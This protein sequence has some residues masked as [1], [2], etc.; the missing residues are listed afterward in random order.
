MA[1]DTGR[2]LGWNDSI[3]NDGS[4]FVL[5]EPGEYAFQV[6]TFER[7]R[8][9]GSA[10]LPA[11]NQ[12]ILSFAIFDNDGNEVGTIKK[13]NLFL[14]T[15]TEGMVCAFFRAIGAR[16]HGEKIVMDWGKV[17][18]ERG[19]CVIEIKELESSKTPGEKFKINQIKK[20]LDPEDI[21]F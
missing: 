3:E 5:I 13:H 10:K 18:G 12:A 7:G 1:E 20:F 19:R 6:K 16:K 17:I 11:C 4:D 14:H 21:P 9:S 8:F 2:E 15:K